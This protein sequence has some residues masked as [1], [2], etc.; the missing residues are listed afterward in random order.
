MKNVVLLCNVESVWKSCKEAWG[1]K[2]RVNFEVL[3]DAVYTMYSEPISLQAY[4]YIVTH[5]NNSHIEFKE[6]LE[7]IGYNVREQQLRYVAGV[8]GSVP[9]DM[10]VKIAVDSVSLALA[11]QADDFVLATGNDDFSALFSRLSLLQKTSVAVT[12]DSVFSS[13]LFKDSAK[14]YYFTKDIIY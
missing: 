13:T 5:P 14:L 10:S 11:S 3:R 1:E 7:A 9:M 4:A 8:D 12:F 2:A 6:V